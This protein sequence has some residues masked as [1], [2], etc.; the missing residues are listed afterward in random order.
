MNGR[1]RN[2]TKQINRRSAIAPALFVMIAAGGTCLAPQLA[3]AAV[4]NIVLDPRVTA[5]PDLPHG[6]FVRLA[7][8]GI[9]GVDENSAIVTHDDGKTWQSRPIFKSDKNF[10]IRPERAMMRTKAG[11][12]VLIFA[13]DAVLK[14]SWDKKKN[15]PLPDMHLPSYSIRSTD[16]GRTW[17][18]LTLLDDGWCGCIQD[19][20]QTTDGKIIVPGQ[21]M[22]FDEGR[23]ATMPYV[24]TDEGKTWQRT[25]YLDIGGRGDHAGAI[26]GTLEQLRDGK[27]RMLLRSYHGF[28]YDSFSAD[29]GLTW[30]DPKPSSIKTT[31]S[32]GKMKRL[33]SGRLMLLHNAPGTGGFARREQLSLCL[34]DDDGQTWS[35]PQVIATNKGGR[36]SYPHLFEHSPGLLWI[37]TMQGALR[38][39]LEE[40]DFVKDWEE[41]KTWPKI[42]CFGDSTTASRKGVMIYADLL[43][44]ELSGRG[45]DARV[46]NSGVGSSHTDNARGRFKRDVLDH[47]PRVAV[48][49]FGINDSAVDVWRNPPAT[50]PRLALSRYRE[51]LEFFVDTL[52]EHKCKVILMTPNPLRW[53]EKTRQ[54]YGRPPYDPSDVDGFNPLLKDYAAA[55]RKIA[56]EKGVELIDVYALFESY[57]QQPSQS[58]DDLL[59]D[60][61]HP[62]STGHRLVADLLLKKIQDAMSK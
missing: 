45:I 52:R 29:G 12:I 15:V 32:P 39:S 40:A 36:V 4:D 22:L 16:E 6:P 8:G 27:I 43:R 38:V 49:Q 59:L 48:I 53:V 17:T 1:N 25:R 44:E 58:M 54:L 31:G 41:W 55:V 34:S 23:H 56:T 18:D 26:E 62:N 3:F 61:M 37:T 47:R 60:G 24:S 14:Y 30:T 57:D 19:I 7:D 46:E 28:F 5:I 35:P 20:I 50:K 13:N 2:S 42:V 51:N 11:T 21:E 10:K 33:A 9:M